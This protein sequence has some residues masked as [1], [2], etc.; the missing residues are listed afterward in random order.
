MSK[1][2]VIGG[3]LLG[4][5]VIGQ[6][7][8]LPVSKVTIKVLDEDGRPLPN[9]AVNFAFVEPHPKWGQAVGVAVQSF[10]DNEGKATGSG[11]SAETIGCDVRMSGFYDGGPAEIRFHDAVLG[12][13]QPWNPEYKVILKMITNPIPMYVK[14]VRTVMPVLDQTIGFDLTAGDWVEP[15]GGGRHSDLNFALTRKLNAADD[16]S[17]KL[18]LSFSGKGD[19]LQVITP[20]ANQSR[21]RLK[22]PRNAPEDG[23]EATWSTTLNQGSFGQSTPQNQGL[24]YFFRVRSVLQDEKV[25]HGLYG[26]IDGNISIVGA[27]ADHPGI[28]FTYYFNP[29]GTTNLE[30]DPTKNLLKNLKDEEQVEMP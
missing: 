4:A 23:Y 16:L 29:T 11:N 24:G 20:V 10:T 19:G 25:K 26:K 30:F 18:L 28:A 9:C 3:V 14:N 22:L 15:F 1:T 7:E 17:A 8:S 21:S 13:W 5:L 2:L 6:L 12:K 27:A